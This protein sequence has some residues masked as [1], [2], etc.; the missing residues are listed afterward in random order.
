MKAILFVCSCHVLIFF[1]LF[2]INI[3]AISIPIPVQFN[4]IQFNSGL[5]LVFCEVF[6]D[7]VE[8][9]LADAVV[10]K[11]PFLSHLFDV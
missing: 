9:C 6:E 4:S 3:I 2:N 10:N 8:V 7:L 5:C 1:R 11:C